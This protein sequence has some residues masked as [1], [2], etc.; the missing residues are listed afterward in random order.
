MIDTKKEQERDELHRAIW[1]IADEL[2]G[3]VDGWDFKNYVLGTMFYRYIS[4]NLTAYVNSGEIEAGNTEFDYAKM[5]DAEAEEA[6]EG[7]VEEKGFFILPS[8]LFC[9]VRVKASSDENLNETLERVFRNIEESAKG[10][11]SE[12]SFA[13]LFDDFDVNS[14]KLGSTVAKRMMQ[15]EKYLGTDYYPAIL[16]RDVMDKV[17]AELEKRAT[18]LG[19]VFEPKE[20]TK[21]K[22]Q[23]AFYFGNAEARFQDPYKQAEYLYGLIEG[24]QMN[25]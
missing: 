10:S 11:Q 4:E 18:G 24:V 6:R 5:S 15:N 14:N 23:K 21:R 12:G 1:A 2:R 7:L 20:K 25:G 22:V 17:K 13:G 8:E 19:R 3:A 16:T 9:N